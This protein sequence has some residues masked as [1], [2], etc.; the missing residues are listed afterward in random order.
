MDVDNGSIPA[1]ASKITKSSH[2]T[3][4]E[5][6]KPLSPMHNGIK[7]PG[8]NVTSGST[9][10]DGTPEANLDE[11]AIGFEVESY[12][13][14]NSSLPHESVSGN[15]GNSLDVKLNGDKH[16]SNVVEN[17]GS[18]RILSD[19]SCAESTH[20]SSHMSEEFQLRLSDD[21]SSHPS[22]SVTS[23]TP[24]KSTSDV[25]EDEGSFTGKR[26]KSFLLFTYIFFN[27]IL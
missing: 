14:F 16:S 7:Y 10:L 25:D 24:F 8:A 5:N 1:E 20:N 12:S 23:S 11:D 3:S 27:S 18:S 17:E 13:D 2:V 6:A 22:E 4:D 21:D 9:S 26:K 15:T 19:E